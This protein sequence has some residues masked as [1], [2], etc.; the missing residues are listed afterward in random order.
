MQKSSR[1]EIISA[2]QSA[3]GVGPELKCTSAALCAGWRKLIAGSL[4]AHLTSPVIGGGWN[5]PFKEKFHPGR[6]NLSWVQTARLWPCVCVSVSVCVSE[7]HKKK[8]SEIVE[9]PSTTTDCLTNM[10]TDEWEH[11]SPNWDYLRCPRCWPTFSRWAL[12]NHRI[13]WLEQ[14]SIRPVTAPSLA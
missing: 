13:M 2:R 7:V 10:Q 3:H 6:V 4:P 9:R 14:S 12:I 5:G 1:L 11:G 8:I